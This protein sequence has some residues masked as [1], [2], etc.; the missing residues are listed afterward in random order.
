M[1]IELVSVSVVYFRGHMADWEL[2]VLSVQRPEGIL[3]LKSL[4]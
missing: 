2:S 4:A 3:H 1:G